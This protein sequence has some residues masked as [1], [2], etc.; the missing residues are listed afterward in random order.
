MKTG[1][2][3]TGCYLSDFRETMHQITHFLGKRYKGRVVARVLTTR[4]RIF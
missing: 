2:D 4:P 3:E 1:F